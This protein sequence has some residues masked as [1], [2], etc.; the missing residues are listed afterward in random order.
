MILIQGGGIAGLTL[1]GLLELK[2]INY[3]VIEKTPKLQAIG[4]G[5]VLQRN[6]LAVLGLI[7][8][9]GSPAS[10]PAFYSSY[11]AELAGMTIGTPA[12]P[13]LAQIPLDDSTRSAG[14]HRGAL[15]RFLLAQI[16]AERVRLNTT[17]DHWRDSDQQSLSVVLNDGEELNATLLIGADG[18][19]SAIRRKLSGAIQPRNT[20][21]W[22]ARTI[23]DGQP[24]QLQ[25]TEIQG[26]RYRFGVVPV[27]NNQAYL[28]WVKSRHDDSCVSSREI[29]ESLNEMGELGARV[30]GHIA[31]DQQWL[32]HPLQ[33]IPISWGNGRVILIGDAAHAVTPNLGQGAALGIEDAYTLAALPGLN[34]GFASAQVLRKRRHSRVRNVRAMSYLMGK[35]AHTEAPVLQHLRNGILSHT[36]A[37]RSRRHL[38]EWL[39]QFLN[40]VNQEDWTLGQ[41]PG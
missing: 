25:A 13:M 26:G 2:G 22:C 16:P 5:I 3:L 11:A 23:L 20:G 34:S 27:A 19:D 32:Q 10:S 21:Q 9:T 7:S 31:I 6:A 12:N 41:P 24:S 1:A 37:D 29:R 38:A 40:T 18:I 39:T 35:L 33:D 36:S 15:Q 8:Q 17:V 4:A 14:F 28:F 30:C